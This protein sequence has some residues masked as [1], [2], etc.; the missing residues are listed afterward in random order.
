MNVTTVNG[1]K[2]DGRE[3]GAPPEQG[4]LRQYPAIKP[5]SDVWSFAAALSRQQMVLT[6]DGQRHEVLVE[7]LEA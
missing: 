5:V 3:K 4:I 1:R 6:I 7:K 2:C